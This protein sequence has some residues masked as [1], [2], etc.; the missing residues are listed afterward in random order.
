MRRGVDDPSQ[1]ISR[2][3]RGRRWLLRSGILGGLAAMLA[4]AAGTFTSFFWPSKVGAFGGRVVAGR[5]E[6]FVLG[7]PVYFRAGKFY[8]MR[9]PEGFLALYRK[10]PHLGCIVPWRPDD[11]SEDRIAPTGRF[12]CPCHASIY[13]RYGAVIRTPAPRPMDLM[14]IELQDGNLV[15]DTATIVERSAFDPSQILRI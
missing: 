13:D 11:P 15:V 9:L 3:Q 4:E 5:P 1:T 8:L 14:K 2:A 7:E 10:C 12:N 6:D